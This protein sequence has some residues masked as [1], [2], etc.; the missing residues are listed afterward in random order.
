ME[1]CDVSFPETFD[2][3]HARE[4]ALGIL[5]FIRNIFVCA[6]QVACGPVDTHLADGCVITKHRKCHVFLQS[7]KHACPR[8]GPWATCIRLSHAKAESEFSSL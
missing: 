3:S 2:I 1:G 7:L 5:L 6:K 8:R 4:F